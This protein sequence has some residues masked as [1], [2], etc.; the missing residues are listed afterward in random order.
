MSDPMS[1]ECFASAK[2]GKVNG[3]LTQFFRHAESPDN[4]ASAYGHPGACQHVVRQTLTFEDRVQNCKSL[5]SQLVSRMIPEWRPLFEYWDGHYEAPAMNIQYGDLDLRLVP[6]GINLGGSALVYFGVKPLNR[7]SSTREALMNST[8]CI[9][10]SRVGYPNQLRA[11][12]LSPR[13]P[14]WVDTSIWNVCD[15]LPYRSFRHFL[16]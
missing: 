14:H 13:R 6:A 15:V 11:T 12:P 16:G 8:A 2:S 10:R 5:S 9:R 1:T 4:L 3:A 7:D